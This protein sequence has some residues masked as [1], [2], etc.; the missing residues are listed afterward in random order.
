MDSLLVVKK[1][2]KELCLKKNLD[3][4]FILENKKSKPKEIVY[5]DGN[6]WNENLHEKYQQFYLYHSTKTHRTT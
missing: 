6:I 5:M 3:S 2:K 1:I 4:L